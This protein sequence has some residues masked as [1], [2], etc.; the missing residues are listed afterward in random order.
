MIDEEA[1]RSI[2]KLHQMKQGGI[3]S[4]T[5]FEAAK[6]DLL[7][8]RA[9]RARTADPASPVSDSDHISPGYLCR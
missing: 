1:L 9:V 4:E 8:G 6:K 2:E 5:D 7:E 3:I